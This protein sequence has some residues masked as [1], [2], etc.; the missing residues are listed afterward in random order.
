MP[1]FDQKRQ[2]VLGIQQNAG[3]DI[4]NLKAPWKPRFTLLSH[5]QPFIGRDEDLV[6]LLQQFEGNSGITLA[7]CGPGGIGKTALVNEAIH[8][9][10]D[11]KKERG[12]FPDGIF[13]HSFYASPSLA[14]AFEELTH[15]FG[16]ETS[17]DLLLAARRAVG[18]RR[19]LL[20]FDG[21]ECLDDSRPL[22]EL[23]GKNVVLL[24]S[25][26]RSDAP[27]QTHRRDL[28]LLTDK[29][30]ITLLQELAGS[31][32]A[33]SQR[34]EQLVEY[35]KGYPLALQ[36]IGGYLSSHE[37]DVADYLQWFEREGLGA[38][39]FGKHPA[40]SIPVLLRRTYESLASIEQD[41]FWLQGLFAS[42]PFPLE[43]V[44][45]ILMLSEQLARQ[46]LN[47]LVNQ[48]V[49]RR[50][51]Q[52]YEVS[53]PLIHTFAIEQIFFRAETPLSLSY[54]AISKWQEQFVNTLSTHFEQSDPYDRSD[55]T[56][57]YPHVLRLLFVHSLTTEQ[58]LKAASLFNFAGIDAFIQGKHVE[59]ES[60]LV[61]ALAIREQQLK[62]DHSD[63]VISFHNL[64]LLY[65]DQGKYIEAE[66]L[67]G[68]A[69]AYQR[70]A[71]RG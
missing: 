25:R 59:A 8:R 15:V 61:R 17:D 32:A 28:G 52:N 23:G 42:A 27:D 19:A 29:Q 38:I 48:S 56:L 71:V 26:R 47:S 7:V 11:Q 12:H 1:E 13:Y 53:H 14:V 36:I 34:V 58:S 54:E 9:L 70:A 49:L 55:F 4:I 20:I 21:V 57:W 3:R 18:H 69:W 41:V 31:R 51:D 37:E 50:P 65:Q 16:E 62:A 64:A 40:E 30:A 35:I 60:L 63:I 67:L 22:R 10:V 33:D 44:Q 2:V 6:W 66:P 5:V 39:D 24:L 45:D 68:R 46:T 43:L